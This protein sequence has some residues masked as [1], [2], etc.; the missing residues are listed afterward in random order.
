MTLEQCVKLALN[1]VL[2]GG[3]AIPHCRSVLALDNALQTSVDFG[4]HAVDLGLGAMAE[5]D[6][7]LW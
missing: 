5:L 2:A 1:R 3:D 6:C 4:R 7:M